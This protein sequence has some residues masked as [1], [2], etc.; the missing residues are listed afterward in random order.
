MVQPVGQ[1]AAE[2]GGSSSAS[3]PSPWLSPKAGLAADDRE[4]VR[5]MTLRFEAA[6]E[7]IDAALAAL[8]ALAARPREV[9]AGDTPPCE[10][11]DPPAKQPSPAVSACLISAHHEYSCAGTAGKSFKTHTVA[12]PATF[13]LR[14]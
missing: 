12:D 14:T 3:L 7:R 4:L 8:E 6:A 5:Q 10:A 2:E 1:P 9:P 13:R 11:T